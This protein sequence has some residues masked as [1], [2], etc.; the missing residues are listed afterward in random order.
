MAHRYS[1][2]LAGHTLTAGLTIDHLCRVRLCV[3]PAHLEEV[4]YGEN[5]RRA[6]EANAA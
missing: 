3:N 6:A 2:V 4:T 1:L 5:L